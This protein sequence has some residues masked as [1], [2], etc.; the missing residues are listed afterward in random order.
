[1]ESFLEDE[2]GLR[3]R[4][5]VCVDNQ[6]HA[7]DHAEYSLDLTTEVGVTGSINDID[8]RVHVMNGGNFG[9]NRDAFLALEIV[10][11][12]DTNA[13][14]LVLTKRPC[15]FENRIYEGRL[16][17]INVRNDAYIS[18]LG[19]HIDSFYRF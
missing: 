8:L 12:H 7:I 4:A 16:P 6:K 19:G 17:V 2:P 13:H 5:F 18:Y 9:K 11:I 1:M 10:A 3:H 14:V 15:L